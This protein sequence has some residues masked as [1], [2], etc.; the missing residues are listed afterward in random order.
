MASLL[1]RLAPLAA[2]GALL[3]VVP[4]CAV[5]IGEGDDGADGDDPSAEATATSEDELSDGKRH[6]TIKVMSLNLR[7]DTDQ[8]TRRFPLVAAEIDRLDPDFVGLQEIADWKD[9]VD[10]LND[11]VQKRGHARYHAYTKRKTA[12]LWFKGEAVG[13]MSRWKIEDTAWTDLEHY[14]PGVKATVRVADGLVVDVF[15]THLHHEGGDDVRLPQAERMT[16]FVASNDEGRLTFLTG[17][18]NATDGSRAIRHFVGAGFVDSFA[19]VHGGRA[20]T[21]GPTSPVR[22]ADGAFQQAPKNRIDYVFA[23]AGRG[24]TAKPV[25]S[26]VVLKNHDAKGFYPSDH[27]AVMTTF[28]VAY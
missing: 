2:L 20:N 14:R 26:E 3:A 11:L 19:A 18:M 7:H 1:A 8:W 10:E 25:K 22:L 13:V 9:Q 27:F 24:V 16:R 4:A 17:D 6:R 21:L 5:E 28:D 12:W 23:K 15:D